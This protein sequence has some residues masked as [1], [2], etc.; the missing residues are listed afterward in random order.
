MAPLTAILTAILTGGLPR[1]WRALLRQVTEDE[2]WN[3]YSVGPPY[4]LHREDFKKV[5]GYRKAVTGEKLACILS[6]CRIVVR[7]ACRSVQ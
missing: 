7:T 3:Y 5:G 6:R 1:C 4:M 2:A